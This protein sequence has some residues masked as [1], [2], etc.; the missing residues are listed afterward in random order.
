MP[1]GAA[2]RS[3]QIRVGDRL[4]SCNGINLRNVS[5]S[6]CLSV[7]KSEGNSGDLELELLRPKEN[8]EQ[9]EIS[10]KVSSKDSPLT[11]HSPSQQRK[12]F[13]ADIPESDSDNEVVLNK[14][15][16]IDNTGVDGDLR[17]HNL[18]PNI[19]SEKLD[20]SDADQTKR[21]IKFK[22]TNSKMD[23]GGDSWN[24]AVPPPMEFST[25][26]P[27][28]PP[29]AEFSEGQ[30]PIFNQSN[31][32]IPVTNIDEIIKSYRPVVQSN[33]NYIPQADTDDTGFHADENGSL[34]NS[35]TN[36]DDNLP[37]E[38]GLNVMDGFQGINMNLRE[39][40]DENVEDNDID[41]EPFIPPAPVNTEDLD[42]DTKHSNEDDDFI[43]PVKVQ[44]QK[45][46]P[47]Q[48]KVN[49]SSTGSSEI[50]EEHIVPSI[51]ERRRI[52]PSATIK[53]EEKKY[54]DPQPKPVPQPR[55]KPTI[56]NV[57][58]SPVPPSSATPE[59][60]AVEEEIVSMEF[61]ERQAGNESF[62]KKL[63]G[64]VEEE[65][66]PVHVKRDQVKNVAKLAVITN[67]WSKSTS[68]S[69]DT[70]SENN[71]E[72][73]NLKSVINVLNSTPKQENS[74]KADDDKTDETKAVREEEKPEA[75]PKEQG[76]HKNVI[77]VEASVS[78]DAENVNVI[79][80]YVDTKSKNVDKKPDIL[81]DKSPK[82]GSSSSEENKPNDFTLPTQTV[83]V[84]STKVHV[85]TNKK[86]N[87][88]ST[89]ITDSKDV[90][91]S[92]SEA[93]KATEESV[94]T[95][96]P[97]DV[98]PPSPFK[99]SI[100]ITKPTSL[101]STIRSQNPSSATLKPL[102]SIKPIAVTSKTF[103]MGRPGGLSTS[104]STGRHSLLSTIHG[105]ST[106]TKST[107]SEE[108]PFLVSVLKGILGVGMKVST[109]SEGF[110]KVDEIQSSGPIAK[111]GNIR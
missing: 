84:N 28:V 11:L 109:T 39:D 66:V 58:H 56:I 26:G 75:K 47:F 53:L 49:V 50:E 82:L 85:K 79:P 57:Q 69:K 15:Q 19:P 64:E 37:G 36:F 71:A 10:L 29:P 13:I 55:V 108:E 101:L 96:K 17:I 72:K 76:I 35:L 106:S 107:R 3:Q 21:N 62:L 40:Q 22:S 104:L 73:K 54:E 83:T 111:D 78:L 93:S 7:L 4:V 44:R 32:G 94:P 102:S 27:A 51:E 91:P 74:N 86:E 20:N 100:G 65:I 52:Q 97:A 2:A 48:S 105:T 8:E 24:Y 98:L 33:D 43:V 46:I 9:L 89:S 30:S 1:S 95:S 34:N 88:S 60:P 5:Q 80:E 16:Y 14:F 103:S 12:N 59:E 18:K 42:F 25:Y 77:K 110:V 45:H 67:M 92:S 90:P 68:K 31:N 63:G 81:D 41:V 38:D 61:K 70:S 99:S 23:E 87:V 6:Q